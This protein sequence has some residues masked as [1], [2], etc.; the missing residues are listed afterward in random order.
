MNVFQRYTG[1]IKQK[2]RK[3]RQD[4]NFKVIYCRINYNSKNMEKTQLS[5]NRRLVK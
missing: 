3:E 2:K 5:I 1:K 4:Y